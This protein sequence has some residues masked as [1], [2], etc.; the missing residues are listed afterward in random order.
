[1]KLP[2]SRLDKEFMTEMLIKTY[3]GTGMDIEEITYQEY[4]TF[5]A[6]RSEGYH[7]NVWENGAIR[8]AYGGFN[9]EATLAIQ[10]RLMTC[11]NCKHWKDDFDGTRGT[12]DLCV[13][14]VDG[15]DFSDTGDKLD[16]TYGFEN[17]MELSCDGDVYNYVYHDG[18][19]GYDDKSL[20]DVFNDIRV[21]M[22]SKMNCPKHEFKE[23]K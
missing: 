7:I 8:F 17:R 10:N 23:V 16:P 12:C 4:D 11:D 19:V 6:V 14:N 9:L 1:M 15:D 3:Y 13:R 18:D 22:G 20:G 21:I 2:I 5:V